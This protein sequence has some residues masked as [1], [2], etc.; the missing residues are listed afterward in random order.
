MSSCQTFTAFLPYIYTSFNE[1]DVKMYIQ[2]CMKC[3]IINI[4]LSKTPNNGSKLIGC[5][6]F[7]K[8][9]L[10]KDVMREI[11][12]DSGF[13]IYPDNIGFDIT[14]GQSKMLLV[15]Y[16][17]KNPKGATVNGVSLR[18]KISIPKPNTFPERKPEVV[19]SPLKTKS[20]WVSVVEGNHTPSCDVMTM[21]L[22]EDQT[23]N[24]VE[25]LGPSTYVSY[26]TASDTEYSMKEMKLLME[27]MR[28]EIIT[29]KREIKSLREKRQPEHLSLHIGNLMSMNED[30]QN[31]VLGNLLYEL[32]SARKQEVMDTYGITDEGLFNVGKFVGMFLELEFYEKLSLVVNKHALDSRLNDAFHLLSII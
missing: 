29:L 18:N 15:E 5:V 19:I 7:D 4:T 8:H 22:S 1:D 20:T 11:N 3:K 30:T 28:E 24:K 10:T 26:K 25:L 9:S 27:K 14:K 13:W 17:G 32:I 23:K 31:E 12:S 21:S 16:K 2:S 6:V